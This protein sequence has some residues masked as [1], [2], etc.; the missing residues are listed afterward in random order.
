MPAAR[1]GDRTTVAGGNDLE[2]PALSVEPRL[3]MWRDHLAELTG[4]R[5]RLAGSGST[6]FVAGT[7][8]ELGLGGRS[9]VLLGSERALVVG[10]R[11]SP[12]G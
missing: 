2:G 9:E 8:A 3:G 12:A 5:P 11:T 7:P 4:R 6:W 1:A 10:V